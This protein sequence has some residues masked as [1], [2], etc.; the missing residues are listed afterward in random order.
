MADWYKDASGGLR[1]ESSDK[2]WR[3]DSSGQWVDVG[4]KAGK[5][6]KAGGNGNAAGRP[7]WLSFNVFG[8]CY[9]GAHEGLADV[10]FIASTIRK[11]EH[12]S[13]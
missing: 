13:L 7:C 2:V 3:Q 11:V 6:V 1:S 4:V 9:G 12:I 8:Y 5:G 10:E